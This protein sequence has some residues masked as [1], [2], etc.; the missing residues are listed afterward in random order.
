MI[1]FFRFYTLLFLLDQYK[2]AGEMHFPRLLLDFPVYKKAIDPV[3]HFIW[4]K[5]QD[6]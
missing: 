3:H 4:D 6:P 1:E 2:K 5:K